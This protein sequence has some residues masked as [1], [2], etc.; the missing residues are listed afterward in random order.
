MKNEK[1]GDDDKKSLESKVPKILIEK[2]PDESNTH[3]EIA[4]KG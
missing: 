2:S 1:V 4:C 3:E